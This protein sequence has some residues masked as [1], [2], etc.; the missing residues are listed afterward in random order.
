[1]EIREDERERREIDKNLYIGKF[2]INT[3]HKK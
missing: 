2:K 3:T 1:M